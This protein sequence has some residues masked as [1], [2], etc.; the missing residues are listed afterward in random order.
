MKVTAGS[1]DLLRSWLLRAAANL[2]KPSK[3]LVLLATEC[4]CIALEGVTGD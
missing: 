1:K 3:T 4:V 2:K